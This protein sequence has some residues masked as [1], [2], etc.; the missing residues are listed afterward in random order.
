MLPYA[1]ELA[2]CLLIAGFLVFLHNSYSR[3]DIPPPDP[4]DLPT[5]PPVI[6]WRRCFHSHN[7]LTHEA[8]IILLWSNA[9]T[10]LLLAAL[11]PSPCPK[12]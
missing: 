11:A 12:P 4:S 2:V 10:I 6:L 9:G 7:A 8:W 3:L 1:T 5:P